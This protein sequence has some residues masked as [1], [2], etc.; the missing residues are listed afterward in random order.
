MAPEEAEQ[1]EGLL[2]LMPMLVLMS[3]FLDEDELQEVAW[4]VEYQEVVEDVVV[5]RVLLMKKKLLSTILLLK[6]LWV[7][8]LLVEQYRWQVEVVDEFAVLEWMCSVE[9]AVGRPERWTLQ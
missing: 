9:E 8:G 1:D 3:V 7:E 5:Q 4:A 2:M 6:M